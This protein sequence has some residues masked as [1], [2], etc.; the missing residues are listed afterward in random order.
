M[1]AIDA[2]KMALGLRQI[3]GNEGTQDSKI[4]Y[5]LHHTDSNSNLLKSIFDFYPKVYI[6]FCSE[7][8]SLSNGI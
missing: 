8:N 7:L 3:A 5:T 1:F 4:A 2:A 6:Q